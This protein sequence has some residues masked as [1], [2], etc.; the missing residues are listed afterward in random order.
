MYI[1]PLVAYPPVDLSSDFSVRK[2]RLPLGLSTPGE[3]P[4]IGKGSEKSQRK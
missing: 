1:G 4:K 3:E 2:G